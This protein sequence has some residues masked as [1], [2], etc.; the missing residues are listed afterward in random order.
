MPVIPARTKAQAIKRGKRFCDSTASFLPSKVTPQIKV[1]MEMEIH[2]ATKGILKNV[3]ADPGVVRPV[4][5]GMSVL[6]PRRMLRPRQ[7]PIR[8]GAKRVRFIAP[9]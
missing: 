1:A 4:A 6:V 5:S 3:E 9:L 8:K 7:L 2:Q